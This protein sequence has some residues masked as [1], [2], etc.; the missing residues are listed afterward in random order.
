[1]PI[2]ILLVGDNAL[3]REGLS[4]ILRSD[5]RFRVVGESPGNQAAVSDAARLK[6]DLIILDL[7][8]PGTSGIDVIRSIRLSDASIP[9]GIL[10]GFHTDEQIRMALNAGASDFIHT[11]G[12]VAELIGT[13]ARLANGERQV[14]LIPRP[15][16]TAAAR[17][18]PSE[19]LASLTPRELEVFRAL[20]SGAT[21]GTIAARF[22]ISRKTLR[23]HI[24]NA[25]H[26]LHI[27]DRAQAVIVAVRE[28]LVEPL[29]VE[30][31]G[32][33]SGSPER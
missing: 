14:S 31:P 10:T 33:R 8:M 18:A 4:Q 7:G 5:G 30:F 20:S 16:S 19:S 24:S 32:I 27:Y 12:T 15:R 26:K 21:I 17:D 6:P 28:G 3:F 13:A 9:I 11:D 22:G 1:M 2:R 25:Y 23:N 29:E